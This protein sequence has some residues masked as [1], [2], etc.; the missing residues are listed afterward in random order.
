MN[1]LANKPWVTGNH[2]LTLT[3]T[4]RIETGAVSTFHCIALP[5]PLYTHRLSE[6]N[7]DGNGKQMLWEYE[8]WN[9][10][11]CKWNYVCSL[12][13]L[14]SV[15]QIISQAFNRIV[16]L[17]VSLRWSIVF[18]RAMRVSTL[19]SLLFHSF[20]AIVLSFSSS[21]VNALIFSSKVFLFWMTRKKEN[22]Y[23]RYLIDESGT[24][25]FFLQIIKIGKF[26]KT[27]LVFFHM[28]HGNASDIDVHLL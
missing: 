2:P 16:V 14:P 3:K 8:H 19:I 28:L 27:L 1:L 6:C 12:V 25:Y 17:S 4:F 13:I 20:N 9:M 23:F 18:S 10:T 21:S 24:C 15:V 7:F 22:F 26:E 5:R 11:K